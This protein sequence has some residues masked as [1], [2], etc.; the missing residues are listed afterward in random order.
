MCFLF[1]LNYCYNGINDITK[2]IC[3]VANDTLLREVSLCLNLLFEN[4]A[5]RAMCVNLFVLFYVCPLIYN[6][7]SDVERRPRHNK[8]TSVAFR[9]NGLVFLV[10]FFNIDTISF[11]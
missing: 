1:F 8:T 9:A 10:I 3:L 5:F 2:S 6:Q 11:I 7:S 4:S